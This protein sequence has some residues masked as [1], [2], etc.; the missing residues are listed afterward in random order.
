MG[1]ARGVVFLKCAIIC[2]NMPLLV[3]QNKDFH[4]NTL[5]QN[6]FKI[7]EQ[8][9]GGVPKNSC[10]VNLVKIVESLGKY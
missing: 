8:P 5:F 2:K 3:K 4:K 6:A 9:T 10:S 7:L 1:L